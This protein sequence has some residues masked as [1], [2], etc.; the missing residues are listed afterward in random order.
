LVWVLG[1][2]CAANPDA[3][4]PYFVGEWEARK[5]E[6]RTKVQGQKVPRGL[7]E[8]KLMEYTPFHFKALRIIAEGWGPSEVARRLDVS[9]YT[10]RLL[11]R[12]WARK[13][14]ATKPGELT[15]KAKEIIDGR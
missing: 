13:L 1:D 6:M 5:R 15:A 12:F 2:G 14:N 11:C 7:V 8:A 9:S 10:A 3:V 4:F